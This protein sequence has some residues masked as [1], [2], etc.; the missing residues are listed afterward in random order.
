MCHPTLT[1]FFIKYYVSGKKRIHGDIIQ[2]LDLLSLS[3]WIAD[4]GSFYSDRKYR[5][6]VGGKICTNSFL[7]D[8]QKILSAALKNFFNGHIG[9]I[10]ANNVEN[11]FMLKLSGSKEV[12]NLLKTI[13]H[14]LPKCIHYKL[15][16]QRLYAELPK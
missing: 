10:P 16:P 8:E 15:D 3:I 9:I 7:Y 14:V 4:D 13:K 6:I 12:S 2:D 5:N 11:Q 1:D